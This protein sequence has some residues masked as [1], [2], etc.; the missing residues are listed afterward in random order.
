MKEQK[1]TLPERYAVVSA[2]EMVYI[3]GGLGA[4]PIGDGKYGIFE[5]AGNLT[6]LFNRVFR[7]FS[8]KLDYEVVDAL[9]KGITGL[10]IV[11][12]VVN[13]LDPSALAKS[14]NLAPAFTGIM[15]TLGK[16]GLDRV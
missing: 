16:I 8:Y 13:I 2:E 4:D 11:N 3:E 10:G 14:I 15:N 1:L 5:T 9:N 7:R 12:A 6:E